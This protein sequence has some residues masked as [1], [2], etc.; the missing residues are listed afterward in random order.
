MFKLS[1][2]KQ[3]KVQKKKIR[4]CSC[5]KTLISIFLVPVKIKLK[6]PVAERGSV[7]FGNL[8]HFV[9]VGQNKQIPLETSHFIHFI[10]DIFV[11]P[12]HN[13]LVT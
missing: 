10:H 2:L 4:Y 7:T 12:I 5:G 9:V 13:F 11:D 6:L 3:R 1:T 8:F